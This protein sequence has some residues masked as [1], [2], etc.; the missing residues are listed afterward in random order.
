MKIAVP[1]EKKEGAGAT[2]KRLFP[3]SETEPIDPFVL[4]DEFLVQP[5][6]G[7]P[8]HQHG[9]FEAITY[10][11]KGAFRHKDNMGNDELVSKG[12]IQKFTSGKGLVH[13]EMPG[14][15]LSQGF[16]LWVNLPKDKKSIQPSYQKLTA[17]KVHETKEDGIKIRHVV[18]PNSPI[19]FETP[20][21]YLDVH[22]KENSSIS[23]D[24]EDDFE[25]FLYIY[26]GKVKVQEQVIEN[27]KAVI[28]KDMKELDV[29]AVEDSK[30]VVIT[31]EPLLEPIKLQGSFVK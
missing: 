24:I 31:G 26:Q 10:M 9:G 16:Q 6:V 29:K 23:I 4:F 20:V 11:I 27:G 25:G 5:D 15:E 19:E 2:V 1:S 28:L 22:M 30:L 3:T 8:D 7:F 14:D 21:K 18:G 12:G 13:S 17:D